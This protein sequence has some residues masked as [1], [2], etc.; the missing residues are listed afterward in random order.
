MFC[1]FS[2]LF[3]NSWD[4]SFLSP[5]SS[6][7][8]LLLSPFFFSLK[9]YITRFSESTPLVTMQWRVMSLNTPFLTR[10]SLFYSVISLSK[11]LQHF[12]FFV[13]SSVTLIEISSYSW[14][15]LLKFID[16]SS[17]LS[18]QKSG[19]SLCQR[20]ISLYR[21]SQL[22]WQKGHSIPLEHYFFPPSS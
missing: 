15:T 4:L 7:G 16:I 8:L 21:L 1:F 14:L 18:Y 10:S 9:A 5:D 2:N 11:Q 3:R 22:E 20:V 12:C 6:L 17:I 19:L 13:K